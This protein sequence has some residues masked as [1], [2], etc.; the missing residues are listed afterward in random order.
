[1]RRVGAAPA[2]CNLTGRL[3]KTRILLGESEKI[4]FGYCNPEK[5]RV[6]RKV[7]NMQKRD[8]EEEEK[9]VKQ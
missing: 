9:W 6:L 1:M 7:E 4:Y 8:R 2:V 3:G 5:S